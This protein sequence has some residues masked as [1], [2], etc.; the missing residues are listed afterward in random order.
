MLIPVSAEHLPASAG[1]RL[2]KT[3]GRVRRQINPSL[4]VEG[5]L[6]TPSPTAANNLTHEVEKTIR[7][8]YGRT[9]RVF[10]TVISSRGLGGGSTC[11][12]RVSVFAYD[13]DGK[14]AHAFE[15]LAEEVLDRG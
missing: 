2:L 3:I 4:E 8:Q 7:E 9:Y 6:V 12:R 10:D 13:E 11:R 1:G 5:I 14:V 15:R